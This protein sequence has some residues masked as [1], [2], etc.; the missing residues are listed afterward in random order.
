MEQN[1][2]ANERGIAYDK[3]K[4]FL[5]VMTDVLARNKGTLVRRLSVSGALKFKSAVENQD[6]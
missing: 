6:E 4:D 3:P 1:V 2:K 5:D